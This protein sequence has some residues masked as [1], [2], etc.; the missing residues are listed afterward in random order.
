MASIKHGPGTLGA[1][2]ENDFDIVFHYYSSLPNF[3]KLSQNMIAMAFE[4]DIYKFL[5]P[6]TIIQ[7]T[8]SNKSCENVILSTNTVWTGDV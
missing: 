6:H 7:R 1:K 4:D 3:K 2:A 5:L 8:I